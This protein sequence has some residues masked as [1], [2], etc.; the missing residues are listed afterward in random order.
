[1]QS[2]DTFSVP[3]RAMD[4]E[5][6][7]DVFR[8]HKSWIIGPLFAGLVASVV[9]AF[10]WPNTYVSSATIKVVPQAVPENLIQSIVNQA[11]SDRI[12]SMAQTVLSRAVLTSIIQ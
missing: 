7:I 3:R 1:M 12:T 6:Y 5:D 9:G 4:I 8:R 2:Q 11:M 10:L